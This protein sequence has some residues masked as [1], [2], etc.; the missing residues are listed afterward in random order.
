M[1]VLFN[2]E[3][4]TSNLLDEAEKQEQQQPESEEQNGDKPSEKEI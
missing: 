1:A 2:Q 4:F 3:K